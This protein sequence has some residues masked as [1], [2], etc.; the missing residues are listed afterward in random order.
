M[1]LLSRW[2]FMLVRCFIFC[3]EFM[4]ISLWVLCECWY[5]FMWF[6]VFFGDFM[7][8]YVFR[9]GFSVSF[10]VFVQL[11]RFLFALV[12]RHWQIRPF[13]W[14]ERCFM[15][16]WNDIVDIRKSAA[17]E[18]NYGIYEYFWWKY[19]PNLRR[20][21]GVF[22]LLSASHSQTFRELVPIVVII[23]YIPRF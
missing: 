19:F 18:L 21:F 4:P 20:V 12:Y 10:Y 15:S 11:L 16:A 9:F 22:V 8:L 3:C 2:V 1:K 5:N 13:L 17:H 14:W 7:R 6:Y 23:F